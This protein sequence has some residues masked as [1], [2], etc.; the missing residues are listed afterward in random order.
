MAS[1][2][3]LL[4]MAGCAAYQFLKGTFLKSFV[5]FM[6]ALSAGI[7]AFAFFEPL[8]GLLIQ[9]EMLPGWAQPLCLVMLFIVAFAVLQTAAITLTRQ[10]IDF[11]VKAE[12]AGRIVLGLLLGLVVSGLLLTAAAM[13]PLSSGFPYQRFDSARP[14]PQHPRKPLL[15]PDGFL[16]RLF[17]IISRGS[18]S[19]SQSFAV[20]HADF[21][22][23]LFLNRIL[24][25]KKVP[26]FVEPGS[27]ML[28]AKAAAWPAPEGLKDTQGNP[29]SSKTGYDLIMVRLGFTNAILKAG[30]TFSTGQLRLICK[31]KG[32]KRS[33]QGSA[34]NVYPAGYI[35]SAGRLQLKGLADQITIQSQDIKDKAAWIDF[36]F[37]VPAG[38]EP[39]AVGFKANVI[40]EVPPMVSA[41]QAPNPI[42]FISSAACATLSAKVVPLT[43]AKI[44]GQEISS[45]TKF[46]EGTTLNVPDR[47]GWEKLQTERSSMPAR[48]E[49]D[50][51]SCAQAELK[52]PAAAA[53]SSQSSQKAK[54]NKLP[55]LLKPLKGY[56]IL[57][58]KCNIPAAG[59]ATPGE[60]L[61]TLI[62]STGAAHHS[63]GIVTGGSIGDDTI[64]EFDYCSL[65]SAI[66]LAEDGSVAKTFPQAVWLTEQAQSISEF[67]VLYMVKT[68]TIILSVRPAGA[69]TGAA[70]EG[71]EGFLVK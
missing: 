30:G 8:A 43:S 42:P 58:L 22:D 21:L 45:G 50:A 68:N 12:R 40:A 15:N 51:I 6:A 63:C 71:A 13:T 20:L 69:Q 41:E 19:G 32:D 57:S 10:P 39:V 67:Y 24:I 61:P 36:A 54:E 7:I 31:E 5:T 29:L 9:R 35:G 55:K 28:P 34:I 49:Q 3:V 14:D 25:D 65:A 2:I 27:I 4:I 60:Q 59:S 53:E 37:H 23:Q 52:I 11:G 48:F 18:F 56:T 16:T 46:L 33:F 66:T 44:Y 26:V 38:F 47:S 1:I 64:F 62:D 70:I 17:A